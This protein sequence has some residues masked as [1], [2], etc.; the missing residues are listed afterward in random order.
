[1]TGRRRRRRRRRRKEEEEKEEEGRGFICY[2]EGLTKCIFH[3]SRGASLQEV[4]GIISGNTPVS[5]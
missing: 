2:Q 5:P 3:V 1:L 4:P